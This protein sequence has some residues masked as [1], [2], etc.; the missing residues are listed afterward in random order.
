MKKV[1][2]LV[3]VSLMARVVVDEDATDEQILDA[4]RPQFA[5]KVQMELEDHLEEIFDDKEC[6]FRSLPKDLEA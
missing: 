2:K 5:N 3:V 1:A 6:P 4:V